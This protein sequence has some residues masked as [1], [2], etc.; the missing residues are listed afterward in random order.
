[1]QAINIAVNDRRRAGVSRPKKNN[2]KTDMTP[3]VD[4][5]FLLISFFVMTTE[6]SKPRV[7]S[8]NMPKEGPPIPVGNSNALTVLLAGDDNVYY[9]HG[10]WQEA[11]AANNVV[12]TSLHSRDGL[13]KVIIEK[14]EW[15]DR[16]DSKERRNG[17]MM[18][19]K[20]TEETPYK[21][22]IDVLDETMIND[23]RKYALVKMEAEEAAW[24]KKQR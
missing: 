7:A 11:V 18:L 24:I 9:Y 22:V 4:L 5:G 17:L 21:N 3:M 14:R 12:K 20:S 15:L 10:N 2:P 8:L 16:H 13:R 1:M 6:L 19:I 23:V